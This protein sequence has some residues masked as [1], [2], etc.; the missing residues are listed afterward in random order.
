MVQDQITPHVYRPS[1]VPH[2]FLHM[3]HYNCSLFHS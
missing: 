1:M 3:A 2:D